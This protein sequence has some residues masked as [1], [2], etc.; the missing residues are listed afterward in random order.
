MALQFAGNPTR[1]EVPEL[2]GL[3]G[4]TRGQPSSVRREIAT[5]KL[6][7]G[8]RELRDKVG[9]IY[10]PDPDASAV[11]GES[12]EPPIIAGEHKGRTSPGIWLLPSDTQRGGVP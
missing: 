9:R 2:D 6:R 12:R 4:A 5:V 7:V 1:L 3:V 8:D 11:G 10:L